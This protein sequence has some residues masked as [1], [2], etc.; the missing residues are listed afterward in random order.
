VP[1]GAGVRADYAAFCTLVH[2]AA[3]LLIEIDSISAI[4]PNLIEAALA[5]DERVASLDDK[6]RRHLQD[7]CSKLPE[8]ATICWVNPSNPDERV[9]AWLESGAPA[10]RFRTL[11]HAPAPPKE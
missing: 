9:I 7:H 2:S 5:T 6:V 1:S 8:V 4:G 10:D 11:G 3:V